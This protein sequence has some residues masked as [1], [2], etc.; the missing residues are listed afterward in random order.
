FEMQRAIRPHPREWGCQPAVHRAAVRGVRPGPCDMDAEDAIPVEE[1]GDRTSALRIDGGMLGTAEH[2]ER[3][4]GRGWMDAIRARMHRLRHRRE[5]RAAS[6]R[7]AGEDQGS[8]ANSCGEGRHAALLLA[9]VVVT[10]DTSEMHRRRCVH[11]PDTTGLGA[12]RR[13]SEAELKDLR[14]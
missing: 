13:D 10:V 7:R 8:G 14:R 1:D 5:Q 6:G 3:P 12:G 2:G 9:F 11:S 4:R